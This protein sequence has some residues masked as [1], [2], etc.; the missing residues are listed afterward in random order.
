MY[1]FPFFKW[2]YESSKMILKLGS[3]SDLQILNQLIPNNPRIGTWISTMM[4]YNSCYPRT[5]VKGYDLAWAK[6]MNWMMSDL[7]APDSSQC[8]NSVWRASLT[9]HKAMGLWCALGTKREPPMCMFKLQHKN[10]FQG[11]LWNLL[12]YYFQLFF[13]CCLVT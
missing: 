9:L 2:Q 7:L 5:W 3:P 13:Y 11:D 10:I 1:Y 4:A 8:N 12:I 6:D